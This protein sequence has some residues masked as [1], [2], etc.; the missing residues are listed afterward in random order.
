MAQFDF[1]ITETESFFTEKK[2]T[3]V[4]IPILLPAEPFLDMAGEDLR[5]RIFITENEN[6]DSLCLRPEFTIPVCVK[7]IVTGANTPR[8][9]SYIG[10]IFRQYRDGENSSFQVGIEDLGDNNEAE[11]DARNLHNALELIS[12]ISTGTDYSIILGD[13]AFFA[14]ILAELGIPHDWQKKLLRAFG[15]KEQLTGLM[16]ALSAPKSEQNLPI[17]LKNL[18]H[19][20]DEKSLVAYLEEEMLNAGISP[21]AG[22]T[23]SEIAKRLLEKQQLSSARLIPSVLQA[24]EEFLSIQ[25]SLDHAEQRLIDFGRNHHLPIENFLSLFEARNS[26]LKRMNVDLSRIQYDAAFGR[27]LD[28]YTG[29]VYEI[30]C[31]SDVIVGGGRYDRLMTMLGAKKP[32][33]AVGF[34][35]WL[36]RLDKNGISN[37]GGELK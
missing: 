4:E 37:T 2:L 31:G 16:K 11:A 10:E 28:Y 33:P 21:A 12:R 35:I 1:M 24:L 5:R 25:V 27:P 14:A 8:R 9:Y 20:Q 15:N 7:H 23:P 26:A 13:Q 3:R 17:E 32:I 29:L 34:S 18:V 6:G 30:R 19:A 36:D 22:R